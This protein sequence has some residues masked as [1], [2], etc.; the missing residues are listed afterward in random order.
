MT[1]WIGSPTHN[2]WL[3]NELDRILEFGRAAKVPGGFGWLGADGHHPSLPT[4]MHPSHLGSAFT[5]SCSS[6]SSR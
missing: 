5:S 2:R 3:E 1:Q 4:P 6:D